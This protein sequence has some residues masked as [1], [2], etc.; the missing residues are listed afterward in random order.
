M[1]PAR[2]KEFIDPL[3]L[4]VRV[5]PI[6]SAGL[7]RGARVGDADIRASRGKVIRDESPGTRGEVISFVLRSGGNLSLA[8]SSARNRSRSGRA[9]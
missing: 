5:D 7:T 8:R 3:M 6:K 9:R 1:L 4:K 2:R